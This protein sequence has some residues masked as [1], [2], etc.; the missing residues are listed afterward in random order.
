MKILVDADACP[1]KEIIK[2]IATKNNLS[3]IAVCDNA[4][5]INIPGWEVITVDKQAD[6]AD[7][8]IISLLN[9]NDIVIT[10]DYGLAGMALAKR[11]YVL[12]FGGKEYT[13]DNIDILLMQRHINKKT[14]K[15]GGRVKG[16]KKRTPEDDA[17]FE[18]AFELIIN[19]ALN[20]L[21]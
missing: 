9:K 16:P 5:E 8:K 4:H 19:R 10:G 15:A 17:Y 11:A 13:P 12:G 6:S 21:E 7:F 14:M 1:V 20:I 3:V 18:K 2:R